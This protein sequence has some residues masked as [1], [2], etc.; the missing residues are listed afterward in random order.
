MYQLM[1][2]SW[3]WI[4]TKRAYSSG[5]MM[6]GQGLSM[7]LVDQFNYELPINVIAHIL[8]IPEE[9]FPILKRHAWDFVRAGEYV[10]SLNLRSKF[11]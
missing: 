11:L 8:G 4:A 10:G 5:G 7:Q 3:C 9:G 2:P 6:F 1:P